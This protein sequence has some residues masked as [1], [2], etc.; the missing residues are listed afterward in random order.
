MSLSCNQ[1]SPAN[2]RGFFYLASYF[3]GDSV[4]GP[5]PVD[6]VAVLGVMLP[7][8]EHYSDF[9]AVHPL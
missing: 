4:F 2:Q 8:N 5:E 3:S 1:K 7:I 6:P 9:A